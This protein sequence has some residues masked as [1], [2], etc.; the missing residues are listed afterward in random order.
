MSGLFDRLAQRVA[1]DPPGLA[2]P[3]VPTRFE[4]LPEESGLAEPQ[5]GAFADDMTP[6]PDTPA[7]SPAPAPTAPAALLPKAADPVHASLLAAAHDVAPAARPTDI[8]GTALAAIAASVP[9]AGQAAVVQRRA[10]DAAV[11]PNGG[12]APAPVAATPSSVASLDA[13]SQPPGVPAAMPPAGAAPAPAPM[14]ERVAAAEV[15]PLRPLSEPAPARAGAILPGRARSAGPTEPRAEARAPHAA[16]SAGA[17]DA[18]APV[19]SGTGPKQVEVVRT[20]TVSAERG[21]QPAASGTPRAVAHNATYAVSYPTP[22]PSAPTPATAPP[23]VE[24]HIGSVEI[25]AAPLPALPAAPPGPAARSL[26][27]FLAGRRGR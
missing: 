17:A 11:V 24:V 19:A 8:A 23:I 27:D 15:A 21:A 7:V 10:A 16:G 14:T 13:G 5:P 6:L 9:P 25:R 22:V 2:W 4:P 3:R 1:G 26:D 12:L 20:E 18:P